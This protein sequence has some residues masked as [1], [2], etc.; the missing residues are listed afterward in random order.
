MKLEEFEI[1]VRPVQCGCCDYFSLAERGRCLVC[2]VCFW[3]DDYDCVSNERICVETRSDINRDLT[4]REAR[5]NFKVF[6][7]WHS[8][9]SEVVISKKERDTL[10]YEPRYI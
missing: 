6:G 2:P 4:L 8:E 10:R 3:E 5:E 9:F 7:A 1:G